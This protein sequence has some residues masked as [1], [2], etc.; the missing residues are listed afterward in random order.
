[1]FAPLEMAPEDPA[2]SPLNASSDAA[3]GAALKLTPWPTTEGV[4]GREL[5]ADE[6]ADDKR[7]KTSGR[8]RVALFVAEPSF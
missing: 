3:L 7:E 8:G 5:G 6:A 4:S 1:M 2:K